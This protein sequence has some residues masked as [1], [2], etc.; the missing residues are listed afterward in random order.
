MS[1]TAKVKIW[2][3]IVGAVTWR[4]EDGMAYFEYDK[5]F[6][7]NGWNLSPLMM[8]LDRSHVYN[9]PKGQMDFGACL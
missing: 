1:S 4:D 3:T 2:D 7:K 8:P 5:R 9:G 6:E